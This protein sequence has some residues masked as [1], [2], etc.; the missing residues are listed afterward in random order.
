MSEDIPAKVVILEF[1]P[2]TV[3]V[4]RIRIY[5]ID[6]CGVTCSTLI[7]VELP[8]TEFTLAILVATASTLVILLATVS[9]SEV[10]S[11][12]SFATVSTS[13]RFC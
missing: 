9:I 4:A 12:K 11:F 5:C 13:Q 10:A 8:A 2:A 7:F 1:W 6:V 3:Y